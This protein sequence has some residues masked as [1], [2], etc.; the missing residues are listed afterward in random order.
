MAGR[1]IGG[2]W[3]DGWAG[4]WVHEWLGGPTILQTALEWAI[5]GWLFQ[6]CGCSRAGGRGFAARASTCASTHTHRNAQAL[7]VEVVVVLIERRL[8]E[9][10]GQVDAHETSRLVTP[11]A[12]HIAQSVAAT[13]QHEHRDLRQAGWWRGRG[14][15]RG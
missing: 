8:R 11:A 1:W 6:G 9:V 2:C 5:N 7:G 4:G 3:A 12:R 10:V 15:R 13:A 14:S